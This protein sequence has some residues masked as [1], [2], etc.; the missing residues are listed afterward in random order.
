ML[1]VSTPPSFLRIADET[2]SDLA[3]FADIP[4]AVRMHFAE[5][6]RHKALHKGQ[7]LFLQTEPAEW[8]YVIRRGWM[9]LFRETLEGQEAV[10]DMLCEQHVLGETALFHGD[11]YSYSAQAVEPVELVMLPLSMLRY[12][13]EKTPKLAVNLLAHT[14]RKDRQ[15]SHEVEQMTTQNA[16]QRI[17]CFLLKLCDKDAPQGSTQLYLPYDKTLIA[18]RLGMKP[19]TFSRALAKLKADLALQIQGA[20]VGIPNVAALTEYSCNHCSQGTPF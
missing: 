19:E 15:R 17:G 12:H 3:L 4:A 9:K 2:L 13:L 1:A 14:A 5:K 10:I 16:A 6:A 20:T 7:I 18:A 8:F 11:A